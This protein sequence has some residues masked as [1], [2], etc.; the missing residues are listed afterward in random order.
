MG[1]VCENI[2]RQ[3][4]SQII[5]GLIPTSGAFDP[6][7]DTQILMQFRQLRRENEQIYVFMARSVSWCHECS[8]AIAFSTS[9]PRGNYGWR[10]TAGAK[11]MK[12]P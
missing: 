7:K 8:H 4:R 1:D 3:M 9:P 11:S 2:S 5:F 10:L 6:A 12:P